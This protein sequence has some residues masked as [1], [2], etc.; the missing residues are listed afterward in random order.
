MADPKAPVEGAA[1]VA[2]DI[3]AIRKRIETL[4]TASGTQRSAT[5]RDLLGRQSLAAGSV[6]S[7]NWTTNQPS[8]VAFGPDI[9][10]TLAEARTVS[11]TYS[12]EGGV[13]G[14]S[15]TGSAS[16]IIATGLLINGAAPSGVYSRGWLGSV[17]TPVGGST[18]GTNISG[19]LQARALV[20]LP[21]GDYT[22]QGTLASRQMGL[23]GTASAFSYAESPTLFVDIGREV[24]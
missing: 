22:V 6:D 16:P 12:V 13:S 15:G 21:A 1:A 2:V 8:N 7:V 20:D 5:T 11:V 10:F 24:R 19:V 4:E 18:H 3:T 23:V 9:D 17:A 14:S